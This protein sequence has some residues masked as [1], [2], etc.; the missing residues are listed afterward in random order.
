MRALTVQERVSEFRDN[1]LPVAVIAE[2]A[3]VER[4][5]VYSWLDGTATPRQEHED[6]VAAL[7]EL[8]QGPFGGNYKVLHRVW[9]SKGGDGLSL[10]DLLTASKVDFD[11]V[12]EKLADMAVTISRYAK[13]E[14]SKDGPAKVSRDNPAIS[15]SLVVDIG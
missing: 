11:S 4:K 2:L 13:L 15:E 12:R 7:H 8:L 1:G 3:Q 9:K 14:T 6:R 5:T 10:R